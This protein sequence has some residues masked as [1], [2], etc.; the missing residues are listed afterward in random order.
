MSADYQTFVVKNP[1]SVELQT[2]IHGGQVVAWAD[3]H[4]LT[5]MG[6]LEDFI[7]SL[8]YGDIE[9]PEQAA[10]ELMERMKWA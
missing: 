1:K 4:A 7:R 8:S 10:V 9:N 6:E 3:G 2:P 5:A